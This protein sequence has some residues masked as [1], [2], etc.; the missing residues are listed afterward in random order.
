MND[1]F[2]ELAKGWAQSVTC[3]LCKNIQQRKGNAME[4]RML[5]HVFFAGVLVLS[6]PFGAWPAP[7]TFGDNLITGTSIAVQPSLAGPVLEDIFT[8]DGEFC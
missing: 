3:G 5:S 8:C 2:D 4:F 6:L 1:K 7:L